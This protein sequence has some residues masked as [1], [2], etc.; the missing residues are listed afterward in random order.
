METKDPRL[1]ASHIDFKGLNHS[2]VGYFKQVRD[3][4]KELEN[5]SLQ[6]GRRHRRL[7]AILDGMSDGLTIL[8]H[9]LNI[10]FTNSVQQRLFPDV[11]MHP[12]K[13]HQ[14]YHQ[15]ETPCSDC[16]ALQTM[17]TQSMRR[18]E[19]YFKKGNL[20]GRYVE[21][22]TTPVADPSGEVMEVLLMMRDITHRK[23]SE[24]QLMQT[25]R[26]AS[27]GF[28]AAGIAHEINNPLYAARNC[29]YL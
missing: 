4:L 16:P 29:L 25:D 27:I 18:G 20:A 15:R 22:T 11:A 6:L 10:V 7:E 23:H 17:N 3:K 26:M 5:L 8:D 24:F 13:C 12:G 21:W 28:L 2:K 14:L 19:Y 9:Q 1:H